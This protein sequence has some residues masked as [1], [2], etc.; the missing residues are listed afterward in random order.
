MKIRLNEL[1]QKARATFDSSSTDTIEDS[2]LTPPTSV[3]S[4]NAGLAV[5]AAAILS[6]CGGADPTFESVVS[7]VPGSSTTASSTPAGIPATN[8]AAPPTTAPSPA[9]SPSTA[10]SPGPAP[11]PSPSSPP[12]AV[13]PTPKD[14]ARFLQMTTFGGKPGE[15][16]QLQSSSYADW[17]D[18]QT[19]LPR[20]K[21]NWDWLIE[22]GYGLEADRNS[23]ASIDYALW[24]KLLLAPDQLRQRMAFALSQIL[25]VG[26]DGITGSWPHFSAAAHADILEEHAFGNF[27]TLL[28]KV[29]L[30]VPM[31]LYLSHLGNRKEDTATG[32]IPDENYAREIMQ[33]FSLGLYELNLDGS[34]KMNG[35]TPIESYGQDDVT[36]L[37]K[38]F[39][40]W[41][42]DNSQDPSVTTPIRNRLPMIL[43]ASNH[44]SSV[45]SFLGLTIPAG[46]S[47]QES[48]RLALDRI[49]NHANVGPFIG[50]QLIQRFVSSNPSP[51]YIS[52]VASAFNNTQGVRGDLKATLRAVLLDTEALNPPSANAGKLTEPILRFAQWARA[53][54][55]TSPNN[56]W[57]GNTSDPATRLGQSPLRSASVFNFFRPGYLPPSTLTGGSGLLAPEMQIL[58]ET[59]VAGFSNYMQTLVQ[60]SVSSVSVNYADWLTKVDQVDQLLADL[61]LVLAGQRL[62]TTSL[63]TIKTGVQSIATTT[64]AGKRNRLNAAILLTILAPEAAVFI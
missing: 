55:V 16:T 13:P 62:S 47:G 57:V 33:L 20:S 45:K 11:S 34:V 31:G 30:S 27:R 26:V 22:N 35:N 5:G 52:R 18:A 14:A 1:L 58:H 41:N 51:A 25:V 6:A 4:S 38:V 10:L 7:T 2:A 19:A 17:F 60:G 9:P 63:N 39:T 48:L 44:S 32:R 49:F 8:P 59:S 21:S 40:G 46:T 43:T 36:G 23:R 64:D 37:A 42:Y 24:N 15:I 50:R 56:Q 29:S 12:V 3:N 28:E 54:G 61:N 53:F